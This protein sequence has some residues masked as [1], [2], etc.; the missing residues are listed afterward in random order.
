MVRLGALSEGFLRSWV[1]PRVFD[2]E[3]QPQIFSR[4][5]MDLWEHRVF[6]VFLVLLA[7]VLA[8]P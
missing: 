1:Y 2:L 4:E 7:H 3:T 5:I 8:I 6:L